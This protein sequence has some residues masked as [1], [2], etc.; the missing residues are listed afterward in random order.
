MKVR[1]VLKEKQQV[2]KKYFDR[3]CT[4]LESL[5]LRDSIRVWQRR[6][7]KPAVREIWQRR[8]KII[9]CERMTIITD[10]TR[11]IIILKTQ[12]TPL[13][14]K[15]SSEVAGD[16]NSWDPV[17]DQLPNDPRDESDRELTS[18]T[19]PVICRV[20]G[21]V[22][23]IPVSPRM[24]SLFWMA[25]NTEHVIS[26]LKMHFLTFSLLCYN[27]VQLTVFAT[28]VIQLRATG[29]D[30]MLCIVWVPCDIL[31]AQGQSSSWSY[32]WVQII[33]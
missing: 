7:W 29:K 8:T 21:R 10:E 28:F 18:A 9:L 14:E 32:G 26:K 25:L 12:E 1:R 3:S 11:G 23:R 4:S 33:S 17:A 16:T 31:G 22:I 15:L 2:Q 5:K 27:A 20:N 30:V 19:S 24:I 6:T 13:Q